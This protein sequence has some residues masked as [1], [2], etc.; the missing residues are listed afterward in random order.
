MLC[1]VALVGNDVS[2]EL[3]K[4]LPVTSNQL[5]LRSVRRLLVTTNLPSSPTLVT[6]M[7]EALNS[8]ETSVL[9]RATRRNIKE[10]LILHSQRRENFKSYIALSGWNL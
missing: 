1:R 10:H 9:S 3:G 6:L 4:T 2:E 8:S 5:F 7:M